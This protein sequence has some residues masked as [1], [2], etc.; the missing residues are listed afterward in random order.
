MDRKLS[1]VSR[2][3]LSNVNYMTGKDFVHNEEFTSKVLPRHSSSQWCYIDIL[4]ML[5]SQIIYVWKH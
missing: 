4:T 5:Q 3:D 2:T 1:Q